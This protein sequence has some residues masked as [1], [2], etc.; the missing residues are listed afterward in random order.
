LGLSSVF[1]FNMDST[2]AKPY[3]FGE[4][5]NDFGKSYSDKAEE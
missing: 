1:L 5:K 4:F 3:S 2:K